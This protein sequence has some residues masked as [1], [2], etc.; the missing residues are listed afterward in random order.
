MKNMLFGQNNKKR[1][2]TD[3]NWSRLIQWNFFN[4][5]NRAARTKQFFIFSIWHKEKAV[6]VC[7]ENLF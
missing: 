7:D 5:K 4:W 2:D 6:V 3:K 1:I